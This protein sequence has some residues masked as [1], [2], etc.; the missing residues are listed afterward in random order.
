M[1]ALACSALPSFSCFCFFFIIFLFFFSALVLPPPYFYLYPFLLILLVGT[2]AR[3]AR[4]YISD[5]LAFRSR[6]TNTHA[7]GRE[8][9]WA[10]DVT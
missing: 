10:C 9:G 4:I 5:R 6:K 3:A 7:H 2:P 8:L 1:R